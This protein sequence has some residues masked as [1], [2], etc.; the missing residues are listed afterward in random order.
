MKRICFIILAFS[1]LT[2]YAQEPLTLIVDRNGIAGYDYNCILAGQGD[3]RYVCTDF[4]MLNGFTR[5]AQ[6]IITCVSKK[7]NTG[8]KIAIERPM[9]YNLLAFYESEDNIN[10]VYSIYESTSKSYALYLNKVSKKATK[11]SWNP[12]KL[13]SFQLERREDVLV[14]SAV[15]PDQTKAA[16]VLFQ[17]N[18]A[19][20][21]QADQSD[22]LKGS[23]VVAFG[24][25][26][27]L[28]ANPLELDFPSTTLSIFDI[29]VNNNAI[30]Y[31]AISSY[32]KSKASDEAKENETL[33]L[34]EVGAEETRSAEEQ[35]TFGN[36]NNGK[37]LLCASGDII[38]GGY[39]KSSDNQKRKA[40]GSYMATF[41][42]KQLDGGSFSTQPFPQSYFDYKHPKTS[43]DIKEYEPVPVDFKEFGNGTKVLLG[44]PRTE[45]SIPNYTNTYFG[46]ILVSF[47]DTQGQLNE[48]QMIR[49]DQV[50]M[51]AYKST[52]HYQSMLSCFNTIMHNDKLYIFFSDNLANHT[53]KTGQAFVIANTNYK[54]KCGL[55]CV[56]ESDG[57][58]SKPEMFMN[59]Q[60]YKSVI[61]R[62]LSID[63]DGL[64]IYNSNKLNGAVSKLKHKF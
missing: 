4:T 16:V 61:Y 22:K 3:E 45:I 19:G 48:F 36:L 38:V 21:F 9:D 42:G 56:I 57:S 40:D 58:I 59:Y 52:K 2:A 26:G 8:R 7:S 12:E 18:K 43:K 60:N 13:L 35:P 17:V 25:E 20:V 53:G 33:H 54:K 10:C 37:L 24:E 55:F 1:M 28:W 62:P 31:V 5:V 49:K 41:N 27:M 47:A 39:Y 32:N 63:E 23:A 64:L 30:A 11:G 50:Y 46:N 34:F 44:E 29:A 14:G 6:E 51:N 15:S